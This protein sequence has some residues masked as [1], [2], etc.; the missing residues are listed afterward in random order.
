M[1]NENHSET[2]QLFGSAELAQS[3]IASEFVRKPL[4]RLIMR[5]SVVSLDGYFAVEIRNG[6][7]QFLAYF[8]SE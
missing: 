3:A 2:A 4:Y 8:N 6:R 7:N 5:Y 1:H